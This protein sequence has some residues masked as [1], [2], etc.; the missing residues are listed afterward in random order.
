MSHHLVPYTLVYPLN[1]AQVGVQGSRDLWFSGVAECR[2]TSVFGPSL[3][4][5]LVLGLPPA[6][7]PLHAQH[8]GLH[9]QLIPPQLPSRHVG[10][11]GEHSISISRDIDCAVLEQFP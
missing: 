11:M 2:C 8:H 9:C 3:D 7:R 6:C 4:G 10:C 1:A 5:Q